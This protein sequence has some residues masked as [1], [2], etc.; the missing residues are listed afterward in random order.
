MSVDPM[1]LASG[2][3]PSEDVQL[4]AQLALNV[5][6]SS[7][8]MGSV[9]SASNFLVSDLPTPNTIPSNTPPPPPMKTTNKLMRT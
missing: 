7:S 4:M 1:P 6:L 2:S 3:L 9:A 8:I 5:N